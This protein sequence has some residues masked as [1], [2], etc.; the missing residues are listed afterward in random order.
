MIRIPEVDKG[1]LDITRETISDAIDFDLELCEVDTTKAMQGDQVMEI[2]ERRL[3]LDARM[4][5]KEREVGVLADPLTWAL[6]EHDQIQTWLFADNFEGKYWP[7]KNERHTGTYDG[8]Y[9]YPITDVSS[10]DRPMYRL[11]HGLLGDTESRKETWGYMDI[12]S[13]SRRKDLFPVFEAGEDPIMPVA[14]NGAHSML[15][16]RN[17][18]ALRKIQ[19]ILTSDQFDYHDERLRTLG[20]NLSK[21]LNRLTVASVQIPNL[22]HQRLSYLNSIPIFSDDQYVVADNY[23]FAEKIHEPVGC[24]FD[25]RTEQDLGM[26]KVKPEMLAVAHRYTLHANKQD[27]RFRNAC[28]A[29]VVGESQAIGERV[30]CPLRN[31]VAVL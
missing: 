11:L 31:I 28:E 6:D 24:P 21:I 22:N 20:K 12:K 5:F 4:P 10:N 16:L 17:D 14:P 18:P 15:D 30:Y 23:I 26:I 1:P 7:P 19:N 29:Y 3:H 2:A 27:A 8:F 25:V 13:S 9:I